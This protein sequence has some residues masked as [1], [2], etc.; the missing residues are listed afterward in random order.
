M[1]VYEIVKEMATA[2]GTSAASVGVGAVYAN[3]PPKPN[4]KKDGTVINAL[5]Q[6]VNIM[7]GGSIKR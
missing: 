6:N 5:D 3:K 4:K 2:G 7:T 1:K